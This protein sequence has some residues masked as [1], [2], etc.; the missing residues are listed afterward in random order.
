MHN[1]VLIIDDEENIRQMLRLTLEAASYEVGEAENG[2]AAFFILNSDPDWDV[3]LLDQRLPVVAGTEILPRLKVLAPSARVLMMTAY[4]SVEL[5][6]EAMK[7]GATDFLRKPMTPEIVRNAVAAA[8]KK[9]T[10]RD[11]TKREEDKRPRKATIT[12]NGYAVL[13]GSDLGRTL[14]DRPNERLF[15]VRKPDGREQEVVVEI[16]AH[17][18]REAG[19]V[20]G[21]QTID[22]DFWTAQAEM[23]LSDFI[24]NDGTVP[25]GKLLL[26]HIDQEAL[27]KLTQQKERNDKT[28]PDH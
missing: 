2:M 19:Q 6:V 26:K 21:S 17:A 11:E 18:F 7:L 23:F 3:I 28:N 14:T 22:E 12:L 5:A 20:V 16:S 13:R 9:E 25:R 4:A 8:L 1:R 24:W 27:E 10:E 15:V